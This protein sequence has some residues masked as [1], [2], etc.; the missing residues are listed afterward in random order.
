MQF[1]KVVYSRPEEEER[2]IRFFEDVRLSAI[3]SAHFLQILFPAI[4]SQVTMSGQTSL[5]PINEPNLDLRYAWEVAAVLFRLHC[6]WHKAKVWQ[7]IPKMQL[8]KST[9]NTLSDF[10]IEFTR[11][12]SSLGLLKWF[13][14]QLCIFLILAAP[15]G[16]EPKQTRVLKT[17][18]PQ[19]GKGMSRDPSGHELR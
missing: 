10:N 18:P 11:N 4:S 17:P 14:E 13:F 8:R 7:H 5:P 15:T 19:S 16:Q 6:S 1:H 2:S 9:I 12:S 3:L